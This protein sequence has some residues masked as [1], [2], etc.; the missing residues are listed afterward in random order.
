MASRRNQ[1]ALHSVLRPCHVT[2]TQQNKC[3]RAGLNPVRGRCGICV[4]SEMVLGAEWSGWSGCL[5]RSAPEYLFSIQRHTSSGAAA[6]INHGFGPM[7]SNRIPTA[8]N[9]PVSDQATVAAPRARNWLPRGIPRVVLPNKDGPTRGIAESPPFLD[10]P[11]FWV[12][13]IFTIR[14]HR[15]KMSPKTCQKPAF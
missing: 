5:F 13:M 6:R 4:S 8:F 2:R 14:R 10:Y 3:L 9:L 15:L 12:W 7:I 11:C 1:I